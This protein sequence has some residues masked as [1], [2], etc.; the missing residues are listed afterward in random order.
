M[1]CEMD[2]ALEVLRGTEPVLTPIA[3]GPIHAFWDDENLD[4]L[5]D[6]EWVDECCRERNYGLRVKRACL[7]VIEA[8]RE[9]TYEQRCHLWNVFRRG[10]CDDEECEVCGGR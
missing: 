4:A 7:K 5:P 1:T 10:G 3:G 8:V 6:A 2:K 9:L